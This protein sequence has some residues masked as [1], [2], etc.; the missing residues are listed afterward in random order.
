MHPICSILFLGIEAKT[1]VPTRPRISASVG[2]NDRAKRF[3]KKTEYKF[4]AGKQ[5]LLQHADHELN[6]RGSPVHTGMDLEITCT[7]HSPG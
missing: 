7:G 2:S 3:H 5:L 1:T 6:S 4:A